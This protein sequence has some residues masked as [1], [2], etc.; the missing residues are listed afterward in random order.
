[1]TRSGN[2]N[3]IIV[4]AALG[5]YLGL[6]MSGAAPQVLANAAMTRQYDVMDEIE[7]SDE[8][9]LKPDD[10]RSEVSTSVQVYVEDV[11]HFLA[12]LSRLRDQGRFDP[13]IDTFSIAQNALLPCVHSNRAGRYTPLRFVTSSEPSRPA[14]EYFSREMV[15]GY[16]LGDCIQNN[17][18][19]GVKAAESHLTVD[20]DKNF[21]VSITVK[22]ESRQN[23]IDLV[24]QLEAAFRLYQARGPVS[25]GKAVLHS[26]TAKA[27]NDQVF[28]VTRL[29]R[30]GLAS[31]LNS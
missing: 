26:T 8:L 15:Y 28:V 13:R 23:A 11:E 18:F 24:R 7:F 1:M 6:V 12:S 30:A 19:D 27:L 20:L 16:S 22:K 31:L 4:L 14:L 29:P 3:S 5:V 21:A 25:L 9:D 17:E 2:Q 10:E